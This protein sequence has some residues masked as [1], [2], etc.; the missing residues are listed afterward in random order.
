MNSTCTIT[1]DNLNLKLVEK[2]ALINSLLKS[3]D[4]F[5]TAIH[6]GS[7]LDWYRVVDAVRTNAI[8]TL[9]ANNLMPTAVE[10]VKC[11]KLEYDKYLLVIVDQIREVVELEIHGYP[12]TVERVGFS[13]DSEILA[14]DIEFEPHM[15]VDI[16][17]P[18][19]VYH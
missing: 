4:L 12:V 14:I 1:A 19:I 15:A 9:R 10:D 16:D 8:T 3:E 11:L 7:I 18:N 5:N 2:K 17:N 13:G 6:D